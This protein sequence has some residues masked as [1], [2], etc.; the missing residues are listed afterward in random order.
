MVLSRSFRADASRS[1]CSHASLIVTGVDRDSSLGSPSASHSLTMT[2]AFSQSRRSVDLRIS[3]LPIDPSTQIGQRQRRYVLPSVRWSQFL[4]CLRYRVSMRGDSIPGRVSGTL[5]RSQ[6][7]GF[8]ESCI[9]VCDELCFR[10]QGPTHQVPFR[11]AVALHPRSASIFPQSL[12]LRNVLPQ[13]TQALA[14]T[15]WR[16][17]P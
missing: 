17:D 16:P 11:R 4:R 9:F 15:R 6:I 13:R 8:S 14:P 2:C 7:L 1:N 5:V 12:S 10:L 3:W